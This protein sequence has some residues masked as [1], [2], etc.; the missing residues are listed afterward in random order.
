MIVIHCCMVGLYPDSRHRSSIVRSFFVSALLKRCL[1][2]PSL[3]RIV[4]AVE[5]EE[6]EEVE[7]EETEEEVEE[8]DGENLVGFGVGNEDRLLLLIRARFCVV[9]VVRDG[10]LSALKF[11]VTVASVGTVPGT[12][13]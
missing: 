9:A 11:D 6:K 5:E 3:T 7:V 4:A 10:D 2:I 1:R 12:F 13:C 8:M